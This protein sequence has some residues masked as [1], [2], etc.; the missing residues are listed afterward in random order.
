[1]FN[2]IYCGDSRNMDAI[3]DG[4][5]AALRPDWR[6]G[7]CASVIETAVTASRK[8]IYSGLFASVIS[9]IAALPVLLYVL[10]LQPVGGYSNGSF[11]RA[12]FKSEHPVNS[13]TSLAIYIVRMVPDWIGSPQADLWLKA[14]LALTAGTVLLR[15]HFLLVGFVTSAVAWLMHDDLLWASRLAPSLAYFQVAAALTFAA[16]H[17]LLVA[18]ERRPGIA[19]VIVATLL[20]A[21]AELDDGLDLV[22]LAQELHGVAGLGTIAVQFHQV[23]RADVH[24]G[25]LVLTLAAVALVCTNVGRH[26]TI[27]L[28]ANNPRR[29]DTR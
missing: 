8:A 24:A 4:L 28:L 5:Q 10:Q 25:G 9:A 16:A 3:A 7:A 17:R 15:P 2:Q 23:V 27:S 11:A 20:L 12:A 22:T 14:A 13:V 19:G 29:A 26:Y 6:G 18:R 1:M 21:A